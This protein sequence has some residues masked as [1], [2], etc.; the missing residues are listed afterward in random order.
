[1]I[2]PSAHSSIECSSLPSRHSTLTG[3]G[4]GAIVL[5]GPTPRR[6]TFCSRPPMRDG[7]FFGK[8]STVVFINEII[9]AQDSARLRRLNETKASLQEELNCFLRELKEVSGGSIVAVI[10]PSMQAIEN[11]PALTEYFLN[12]F[13]FNVVCDQIRILEKSIAFTRRTFAGSTS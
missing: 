5:N 9:A 11:S 4:N 3:G 8:D 6:T 10:V 7:F 1:M 2:T 13:N 12:Q